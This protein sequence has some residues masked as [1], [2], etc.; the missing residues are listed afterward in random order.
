MLN[1]IKKIIKRNPMFKWLER[2]FTRKHRSQAS[3]LKITTHHAINH[4]Y[5]SDN[6]LFV[7]EQL[8]NHGFEAY[9]VG[10]A[11]RDLLINIKPKDFDVATNATP[12]QIT[13]IFKKSRIIGKRFQIVHITFYQRKNHEIIE[14]TTFR[15]AREMP[16]TN[17]IQDH[18]PTQI[19]DVRHDQKQKANQDLTPNRKLKSYGETYPKSLETTRQVNP[20]GQ[21]LS[22]NI[23]GTQEQ[24]ASRRDFT[25]NA[26]YYDPHTREIFDYHNGLEDIRKQCLAIIG[27]PEERYIEDPVRMLRVARFMAK[28]HFKI[29]AQTIEPIAKQAHLL[30]NI[31]QARL[32]DEL[33]K[34]LTSGFAMSCIEHVQELCLANYILPWHQALHRFNQK[35]NQGSQNHDLKHLNAFIELVLHRTDLRIAQEKGVAIGFIFAGVYWPILW[36]KWQDMM[37]KDPDA[38]HPKISK[39]EALELAI[40]DTLKNQQ[41]TYRIMDDMREIWGLQNRLEKRT[42]KNAISLLSHPRFRAGFDF[43]ELRAISE[44]NQDLFDLFHWW[45]EFQRPDANKEF[46]LDA[47]K[48]N[49]QNSSKNKAKSKNKDKVKHKINT[50]DQ[51]KS[52]ASSKFEESNKGNLIEHPQHQHQPQPQ[53]QHQGQNQ[54]TLEIKT[55]AKSRKKNKQIQNI[56]SEINPADQVIKQAALNDLNTKV[57][58]TLNASKTAPAVKIKKTKSPASS[59]SIAEQ[60]KQIQQIQQI[61]QEQLTQTDQ[62]NEESKGKSRKKKSN[63]Q[64]SFKSTEEVNTPKNLNETPS[65]TYAESSDAT[66]SAEK[67]LPIKKTRAK[68]NKIANHVVNSAIIAENEPEQSTENTTEVAPKRRRRKPKTAEIES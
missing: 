39:A 67:T 18:Q 31:P 28:T 22:D 11:V 45:E 15:A 68:K 58:L 30:K 6:A 61:Q 29:E 36:Q 43:L 66:S 17:S 23:W 25:V 12:E 35:S 5:I 10:G 51:S 3:Q 1:D 65:K 52:Q 34:M 37:K 8:Q 48:L 27:V 13:K 54:D 19:Q 20:T 42:P 60:S 50:Q 32:L 62:A 38:A 14:V 2:I 47:V 56:T 59:K 40:E 26:L 46:L 21:L 4:N 33:L 41:I 64:T 24:D 16:S 63:A 7:V 53:H 57:D 9:I 44:Q 55:V 49:S